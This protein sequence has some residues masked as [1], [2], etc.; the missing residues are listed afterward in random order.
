MIAPHSVNGGLQDG[1]GIAGAGSRV[2]GQ[3]P[4][5]DRGFDGERLNRQAVSDV[6]KYGAKAL[7]YGAGGNGEGS[8]LLLLGY[9]GILA[10]G[11]L[12]ARGVDVLIGAAFIDVAMPLVVIDQAVRR[13]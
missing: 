2:P 4:A 3:G 7:R 9:S 13:S 6:L 8:L 1:P 5:A 10:H 11:G 12:C